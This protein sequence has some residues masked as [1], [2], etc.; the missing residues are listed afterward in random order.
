M[1][2]CSANIIDLNHIVVGY[3][4]INVNNI[5]HDSQSTYIVQLFDYRCISLRLTI[6]AAMVMPLQTMAI[7]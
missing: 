6:Q 1:L 3:A 2:N 5:L 4:S 7:K